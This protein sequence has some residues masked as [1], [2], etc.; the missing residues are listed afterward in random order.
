M[1][2]LPFFALALVGLSGC[3]E[4]QDVLDVV[5]P[6]P[7]SLEHKPATTGGALHVTADDR[8]VIMADPNVDVLTVADVGTDEIV[9]EVPLPPSSEPARIVDGTDGRIH[10]VLRG[11]GRL[12]TVSLPEGDV[13]E[14]EVCPE[15]R[16]LARDDERIL[17]ACAG[18]DVVVLDA[19]PEV[20]EPLARWR[21]E[22]D[23]RDVVIVDGEVFVTT[24]R[25]PALLRLDEAGAVVE[26]FEP[27]LDTVAMGPASPTVAW[28][29]RVLP[30]GRVAMLHQLS[31]SGDLGG[32]DVPEAGQPRVYYGGPDFCGG[33]VVD[34]AL[35]FFDVSKAGEMAVD[36]E[37]RV[38]GL[39]L[40][41]DFDVS[42][43]GQLTVVSSNGHLLTSVSAVGEGQPACGSPFL[44]ATSVAY[45]ASGRAYYVDE[46][47]LNRTGVE[48]EPGLQLVTRVA[49]D[50]TG[51]RIFHQSSA[52][53]P[54]A[55]ASCHPEGRDDG[56]VWMFARGPRRTHA[57][58]G[59]TAGTAP[60][61]WEG[62]I[63]SFSALMDEVYTERMRGRRLSDAEM[64]AVE[65][66]MTKTLRPL[67]VA[68]AADTDAVARGRTLY[69]DD[70]VG[71]AS[72]HEGRGLTLSYD[73]GT[74]GTFQPPPLFGLRLRTPLM[75][76]GCADSIRGRFSTDCGGGDQH[77]KTSHLT[78]DELGDLL[79]YLE[80]L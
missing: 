31:F 78:E 35:T 15:P 73:V 76:D 5:S 30:D 25:K 46:L 20:A 63:H 68:R 74:G 6:R 33:G 34:H 58:L 60:Y 72:C 50:N 16:G 8:F 75:H 19:S 70:V 37:M 64:A 52:G 29:T 18:G 9:A 7:V 65:H 27:Q 61:H 24:F 66:W 49:P 62:D 57:L 14:R 2:S 59:S 39:V 55:C 13:V 4:L 1:K 26:R 11:R 54:I 43:D 40:A 53:A 12:A 77:G 69:E 48:G 79:A 80:S 45:D 41:V 47:G 28:R 3:H 71:C 56:H 23:L 38:T 51:H 67:R 10:V 21:V 17:V 32:G 36:A 44:P 42:L 22:P